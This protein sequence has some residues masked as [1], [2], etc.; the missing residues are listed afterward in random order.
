MGPWLYRGGLGV[1]LAL[2]SA[3]S[4][5]QEQPLRDSALR[6]LRPLREGLAAGQQA[7][8]SAPLGAFEGVG[9]LVY[10]LFQ[11]GKLLDEPSLEREALQ[12]ACSIEAGRIDSD[13]ALDV[14][15]GSA[16]LLLCLCPLYDATGSSGLLT[17][18][19]ACA[20]HLLRTACACSVGVGWATASTT[21]PLCGMAHGG[22]GVAMAL[23]EAF[24]R[25]SNLDYWQACM[26]ALAYERS[27]RSDEHRNWPDLRDSGSEQRA[28]FMT[29]WCHGAPGIALARSRILQV[30]D[31][32]LAREDLEMA[33]ETTKTALVRAPHLCCGLAGVDDI[34]FE[35]GRRLGDRMLVQEAERRRMGALVR[36]R[37]QGWLGRR[38]LSKQTRA[39]GF[40]QGLAGLAYGLLRA[41]G[42]EN[43]PCVLDLSG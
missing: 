1:A 23:A 39:Q 12:L 2:A 35:V 11:I 37:E 29:A 31:H 21:V 8:D 19:D 42:A 13:K 43:L 17:L 36:A 14:V 28:T 16:G 30:R 5:S 22:S 33:I 32:P 20:S 26:A 40:M 24:R 4:V 6:T 3:Y 15:E 27:Q 10:A 41:A 18:I 9:G 34:V 7:F 25:T 38:S